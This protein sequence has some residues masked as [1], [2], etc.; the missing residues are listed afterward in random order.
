MWYNLLTNNVQSSSISLYTRQFTRLAI[1][2]RVG[3]YKVRQQTW[4]R[5]LHLAERSVFKARPGTVDYCCS[6]LHDDISVDDK[7]YKF[8]FAIHNANEA[9]WFW[10][11]F[12]WYWMFPSIILN[13][14]GM[15][16]LWCYI[17]LNA[18]PDLLKHPST[19]H[20]LHISKYKDC[21]G[22]TK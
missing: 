5:R 7:E 10:V 16:Y 15:R 9:S 13:H 14:I 22:V 4:V 21:N 3:S 18:S 11:E 20:T 17:S 12:F 2:D 1:F 8:Y 6:I 19:L